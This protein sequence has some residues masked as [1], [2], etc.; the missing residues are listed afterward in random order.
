M[1][2]NQKS[3]EERRRARRTVVQESFNL[4]LVVPEWQGMSRLYLKDISRIGISFHAERE[5][6]KAGQKFEARLYMSPAFYLPLK[7]E[8][9]RAGKGEVAAEF[10][11][12]GAAE[13]IAKLQDFFD[14]AAEHGVL[15]D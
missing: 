5:G 2:K 4:F 13:A 9:I 15:V 1:P 10:P 12:T 8:V 7:C 3:A 14:S 11:D 6:L